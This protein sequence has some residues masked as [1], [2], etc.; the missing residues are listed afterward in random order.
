LAVLSPQSL[1]GSYQS[2]VTYRVMTVVVYAF[3]ISSIWTQFNRDVRNELI[4]GILCCSL[5][6]TLIGVSGIYG[7]DEPIIRHYQQQTLLFVLI[8]ARQYR[9]HA[10]ICDYGTV[11][12]ILSESPCE[13]LYQ[14][15]KP[16]D[17]KSDK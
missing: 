17:S 7:T 11:H 1:L 13:Q 5:I 3:L 10:S 2:S 4:I 8:L 16:G 15:Q 9:L 6:I 14:R 12:N